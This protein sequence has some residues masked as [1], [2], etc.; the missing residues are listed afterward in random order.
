VREYTRW[1]DTQLKI[2]L[3]RLTE[4]EYLLVHRGGRGQSFE[5]ELLFDGATN[6][7]TPHASGLIDIDTLTR[8]YDAGRSGCG[9][10]QSGPSR[11]SVGTLSAEDRPAP[12]LAH[13]E[14]TRSNNESPPSEPKTLSPG[15]PRKTA[16]YPSLAAVEVANA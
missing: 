9:A 11:P 1:G 10:P 5:Y 15:S 7:D 4:L 8:D 2:H 16:S 14:K 13:P 3:A 6:T 12:S